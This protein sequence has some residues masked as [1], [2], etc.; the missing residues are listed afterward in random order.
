LP[1]TT[2]G[3]GSAGSWRS[4]RRLRSRVSWRLRAPS[5]TGR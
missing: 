2:S 5:G 4:P 1:P 3:R